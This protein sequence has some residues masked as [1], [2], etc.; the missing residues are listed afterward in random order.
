MKY[1]D[2]AKIREAGLIT[3]EQQEQINQHF[4]LKEDDN[5]LLTVLSIVGAVLAVC[6]IAL[7]IAANWQEIPRGIKIAMGL[8]LMLGAHA[9]GWYLR[10]KKG[11]PKSGEALHLAGSGLFLAN[12]GLIGQIYHLSARPPN[13][14]LLWWAGI[15]ALPWVLRSKAQHVLSLLAFGFWFGMEIN[16]DGSPVYFGG[17]EY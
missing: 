8:V 16:Q 12:I 11:Y 15:A 1:S 7:L 17:D 10:E 2:I 13:A 9:G 4:K 6:G 5:K 14:F 3:A